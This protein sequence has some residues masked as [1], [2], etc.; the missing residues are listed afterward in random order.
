MKHQALFSS[1][2]KMKN[3]SRL[4]S[5]A[6]LIGALSMNPIKSFVGNGFYTQICQ[7][8]GQLH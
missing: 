8:T 5:A 1:K 3:Y 6:V 2:K 4:Q 7:C